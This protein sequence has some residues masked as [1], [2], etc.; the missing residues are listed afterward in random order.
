LACHTVLI[1]LFGNFS[2]A[3][4]RD[5]D[6]DIGSNGSAAED[7]GYHS[8]SDLEDDED[9]NDKLNAGP[10]KQSHCSVGESYHTELINKGKIVKIPDIAFVT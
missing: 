1:V 2:E 7:Y 5:F 8:D 10:S 9:G 3:E 6:D 4:L